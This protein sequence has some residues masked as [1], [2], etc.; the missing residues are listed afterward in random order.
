M[1]C[2]HKNGCH[3]G[4]TSVWLW[5]LSDVNKEELLTVKLEMEDRLVDRELDKKTE[6]DRTLMTGQQTT[7]IDHEVTVSGSAGGGDFVSSDI[8]ALRS[9]E[10]TNIDDVNLHTERLKQDPDVADETQ[11]LKQ[12]QNV[13][14]VVA[15]ET[16]SLKQSQNVADVVADETESLKQ[17][18]NVANVVADET[19]SLKQS[20]NVADVVADE[21]ES[22]KQ[23]QNV[24]SVVA[25][26]VAD[27]TESLKQS[28]NVANDVSD[29]VVDETESLKQSR[30]VADD[31]SGPSDTRKSLCQRL[32]DVLSPLVS[33]WRTYA[34][35]L[36]VFAGLSL[37]M[38][39]MTVLGFDSITV[40]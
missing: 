11:P 29:N 26:D 1:L 38:L 9:N 33:G 37:A 12:S 10:A 32:C 13:A 24:A 25:D 30:N 34:R 3:E 5:L 28:Q 21:T 39:Y 18:Q 7:P 27:E 22:L 19:E 2:L 17:S 16:E 23:S 40:G 6:D 31:V 8:V 36:V 14:N 15:D 4:N 35:Q 20:Q